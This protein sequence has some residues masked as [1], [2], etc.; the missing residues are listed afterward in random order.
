LAA[1]AVLLR[2]HMVSLGHV[3]VVSAIVPNTSALALQ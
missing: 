3:P 2:R 1:A